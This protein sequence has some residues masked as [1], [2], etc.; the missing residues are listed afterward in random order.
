MVTN[1]SQKN[2]WIG[3]PL[4]SGGKNF[5]TSPEFRHCANRRM[6]YLLDLVGHPKGHG[7]RPH[8][9]KVATI[10]DMMNEVVKGH[11]N[12]SKLATLGNYRSVA[13][14]GVGKIYPRNFAQQR[15]P[16]SNFAQ[17]AFQVDKCPE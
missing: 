9:L 8:S 3:Q 7:V 12:L 17:N 10:P 15:L 5:A 2:F 16:A 14:Q 11:A 13:A 6:T 1:C 4:E